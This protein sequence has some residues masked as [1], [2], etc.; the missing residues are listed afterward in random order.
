MRI[1]VNLPAFLTGVLVWNLVG[2][3]RAEDDVSLPATE[4]LAVARFDWPWWRGSARNGIA[5]GSEAPVSWTK[6]DNV[7]WKVPVP[8]R[9]HAT[10]IISGQRIF[11]ATADEEQGIQ[12]LLSF[13]RKSGHLM[14][15]RAIH[16]G[17]LMHMHSKNSQASATPACDG[18]RVY[19]AFINDGALWVT[20]TDL[21]GNVAWQ[22]Q[23]GVFNSEHGYASSPVLFRSFVIVAVDSRGVSYLAALHRN[24]GQFAW[25]VERG[26]G[27]SRPGDSSYGTPLVAD[28]AGREQLILSGRSKVISYDPHSGDQFWSCDGPSETT[29]NTVACNGDFV[30]VGGGYPEKALMCIRADGEG[31][32]TDTH[33]AWNLKN[34]TAYV[35]TPLAV[36]DRLIIAH[37][38][39][40]VSSFVAATGEK[41]WTKRLGGGFSASPVLA[42]GNV[43]IPNETGTTFVFKIDDEFELLAENDLADGGFA[44]PVFSNGQLFLRTDHHL[45]CIGQPSSK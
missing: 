45:Y 31:D 16:R 2:Q 18:E 27:V 35:P 11:I 14:W 33:V 37:D 21:G 4:S 3:I 29:A 19:T 43:Y 44:S 24:T 40:T 12:S 6:T 25:K 30:F 9:G 26:G 34:V 5:A 13:S 23:A 28:V 41:I 17:G 38:N 1:N 32:V 39:G 36:N 42:G 15:N 20:A 10:P 8:G 22:K 7:V